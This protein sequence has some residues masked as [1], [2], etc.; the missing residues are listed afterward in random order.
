[1]K[2]VEANVRPQ[3][4]SDRQSPTRMASRLY[5]ARSPGRDRHSGRCVSAA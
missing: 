5:A 1:M 3:R 2:G 4:R